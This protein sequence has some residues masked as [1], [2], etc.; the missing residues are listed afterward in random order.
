MTIARY[1]RLGEPLETRTA[2][3]LPLLAR[4]VFAG[5][6]L[7]YFWRAAATKLGDGPLGI[8]QPS[9]G[10]YAQIFPRAMEAAG[11][12]VSQLGPL[13]WAVVVAGT[14]AEFVLPT[15]I[16]LGLL[17]RLAALA[18]IGF[19]VVQ[20][21][22]DLYGHGGIAHEGTLGAW[23]DGLPDGLILDQRAFW[24]LAMV[25]LVLKGGGWLSLDAL[26]F[27]RPAPQVS[28]A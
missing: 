4:L 20:S 26:L 8:F 7:V 12:D 19:V 25:T 3:L 6:L 17:T 10:A 15:L 9:L 14:L 2:G 28:A 5:T 22:T 16:V 18:M 11:Y 24:M 23:F 1:A 27:R 13:H 21:L